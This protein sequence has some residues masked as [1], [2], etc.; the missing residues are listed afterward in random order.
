MPF[1]SEKQRKWMWANEPEMAKKWEKEKNEMNESGKNMIFDYDSAKK[2]AKTIQKYLM[3]VAPVVNV[4]VSSLGGKDRV[5]LVGKL[6]LDP[7]RDWPNGIL[8]NSRWFTFHLENDGTLEVQKGW[9]K[10]KD[11]LR[12]SRNKDLKTAIARMLKYFSMVKKKYPLGEGE[13]KMIKLS[14]LVKEGLKDEISKF[15]EDYKTANGKLK[16]K[17]LKL[18]E[19]KQ[20]MEA[21]GIVNEKITSVVSELKKLPVNEVL[22]NIKKSHSNKYTKAIETL[23]TIVES[24]G[25]W[26]KE[27]Q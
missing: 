19:K 22:E 24:S 18:R 14:N 25:T 9:F 16:T 23:E 5:S 4:S 1:K 26:L 6:S 20:V 8:E 2:D 10:I 27:N 7:K 11:K 3:R 15:K 13:K 12:K 17:A 21:V